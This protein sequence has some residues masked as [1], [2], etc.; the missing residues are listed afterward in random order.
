MKQNS[1]SLIGRPRGASGY[2]ERG[3]VRGPLFNGVLT[4]II[5]A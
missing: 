5:F 4:P 3:T 2:T 1:R